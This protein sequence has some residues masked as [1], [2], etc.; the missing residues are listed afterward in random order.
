MSAVQRLQPVIPTERTY[1]YLHQ[2]DLQFG[3]GV[4]TNAGERPD[5]SPHPSEPTIKQ[6]YW[7]ASSTI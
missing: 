3:G 6:E 4:G 2:A 5:E 1:A 7:T